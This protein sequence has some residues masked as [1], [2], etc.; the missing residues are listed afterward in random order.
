M[1]EG[2]RAA[3]AQAIAD[4]REFIAPSFTRQYGGDF[5]ST[6]LADERLAKALDM[7]A[8]IDCVYESKSGL[9]GVALRIQRCHNYRTFTIRARRDSGTKTELGKRSKSFGGRYLYPGWTLQGYVDGGAL[10]GAA[11][12]GTADLYDGDLLAYHGAMRRTG[13]DQD[14]QAEFIVVKWDCVSAFGKDII[15]YDAVACEWFK[16]RVGYCTCGGNKS[17]G[18]N[19]RDPI[20]KSFQNA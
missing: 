1:P 8:G 7:T 11:I 13:Q 17:A 3:N 9:I 2:Y 15:V 19:R 4:F 6:E 10:V 14:G 20:T 12:V 16:Q 5:I 18:D